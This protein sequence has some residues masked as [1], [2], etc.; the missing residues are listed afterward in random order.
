VRLSI[1][2]GETVPDGVARKNEKGGRPTDR[3]QAS[4]ERSLRP[5]TAVHHHRQHQKQQGGDNRSLPIHRQ[6]DG[7]RE[8]Y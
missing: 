7:R 3:Q 8:C 5:P 6:D 2:A 4:K 1:I